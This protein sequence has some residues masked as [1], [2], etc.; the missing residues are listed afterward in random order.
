[1]ATWNV[2]VFQNKEQMNVNDSLAIERTLLVIETGNYSFSKA[3]KRKRKKKN[4]NCRFCALRT[5]AL[6]V[7]AHLAH[8]NSNA[9]SCIERSLS[10][11]MNNDRADGHCYSFA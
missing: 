10:T 4:Q 6:I 3:Q 5:F 2:F 11:K 8:S 7:Y 1:M 9:R